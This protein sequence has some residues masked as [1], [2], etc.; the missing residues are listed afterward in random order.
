MEK[1][2]LNFLAEYMKAQ[3]LS[4]EQNE[5]AD[6]DLIDMFVACLIKI[7]RENDEENKL[8]TEIKS[9]LK[10]FYRQIATTLNE[11]M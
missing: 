1:E 3:M 2:S 10:R 4:L 11:E 8:R 9:F 5:Q 6:E 7:L